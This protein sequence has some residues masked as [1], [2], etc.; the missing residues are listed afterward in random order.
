MIYPIYY[1][2]KARF[3][4]RDESPAAAGKKWTVRRKEALC[5]EN[6]SRKN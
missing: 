3:V 1:R 2:K 6:I 5:V 4:N